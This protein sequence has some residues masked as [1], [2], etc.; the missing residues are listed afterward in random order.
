MSWEDESAVV[1]DNGSGIV[2]GGFA[3]DEQPR[4]V[5]ASCVAL[6]R[7]DKQGSVLVGDEAQAA[8]RGYTLT[9]PIEHGIVSD[10]DSMER[11]WRHMYTD[12]NA[13]PSAQAVLVTE[14][15]MNPKENREKVA[16]VLFENLEVPAM[17]LQIQAVLA[18]YACGRNTGVVLDSG[19]GVTHAVPV[20]EGHTIPTAIRRLDLA[21][22]DL[23]EW[24][25]QLLSDETDRPFTTSGDREV[26]RRIKEAACYI[27]PDFDAELDAIDAA[28]DSGGTYAMS[29]ELP[30]GKSI[31]IARSRVGCPELLFQ[32]SLADKTCMSLPQIVADSVSE[33]PIDIRRELLKNIV[34]S[35]GSTMFKGI[36]AR[37]TSEI[38]KV[39]N[40]R[41][42]DD[43][44]V[45]A[46]GER[47]YS[48]WIGAAILSSLAS[49]SNEWI[50]KAEYHE[51]GPTVV[52]RRSDALNFAQA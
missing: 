22:R 19:D 21:G 25:M 11:L 45:I 42:Q 46:P 15:P 6:G 28:G 29:Y 7:G 10:W 18:L 5:F 4:S 31:S 9:Y 47:K 12:L 27:A 34:L 35:G 33:C 38:A 50:T 36:E 37:L 51:S 52:H 14:A 17:Q 23:T 49:F 1:L 30:D 13:Q 3:G 2:K 16:E 40:A 20:F 39:V 32:P 41:V 24:L 48:V 8:P 43:V 44:H 26:A